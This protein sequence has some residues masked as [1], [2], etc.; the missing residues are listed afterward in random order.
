MSRFPPIATA[1]WQAFAQ[2]RG[3]E[4]IAFDFK[5]ARGQSDMRSGAC[6]YDVPG[7]HDCYPSLFLWPGPWLVGP[8]FRS[9]QQRQASADGGAV[10]APLRFFCF[11]FLNIRVRS[12]AI[13]T[14]NR[15]SIPCSRLRLSLRHLS[16]LCCPA[17][18]ARMATPPATVPQSAPL[19][20]QPQA[21]LLLTPPVAAKP[22][23]R[24]SA[25]SWA[26]YRVAFRACP[27]AI[28]RNCR[29]S[30]TR[31]HHQRP[32]GVAPRM[33]FSF[34]PVPGPL[35]EKEPCFRKS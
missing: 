23:A 17:V 19:V 12:Q 2:G 25:Q 6:P 18:S 4:A 5:W 32:S 8:F 1:F 9:A 15:G 35:G 34:V 33:A 27:P 11:P 28:D 20:V 24:L 29:I 21:R 7:P 31:N 14:L 10:D 16:H 13:K 3:R 26:A 30:G 22:K